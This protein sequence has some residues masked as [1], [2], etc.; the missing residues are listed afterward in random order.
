MQSSK[1]LVYIF[2]LLWARGKFFFFCSVFHCG[3][4]NWF[5]VSVFLFILFN[6]FSGYGCNDHFYES[7]TC[8][9]SFQVLAELLKSKVTEDIICDVG[10]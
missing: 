4:T 1:I 10:M 2:C 3:F 5:S 6:H 9:H 8:L 7:D